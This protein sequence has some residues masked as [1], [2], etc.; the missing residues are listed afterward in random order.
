MGPSAGENAHETDQESRYCSLIDFDADDPDLPLNWSFSRKIWVTSMVAILN[1]IGTIASSIFGTGI[2]EFMQE[3]NVSNEI[4]VQGTTLFLAGYIFGFLIFGPLSERFGRKWPML[5]G[6]TASSLFDL[7]PALGTNVATVLIGRFFGGLFGVAPVAI[8]G[9]V[10]GDCWPLAQRGIAM[11]LAVS[12]V[13]SGPTWGPSFVYGVM[14]LFYQMYPVAFGDDRNWTTSLK[15]LPLLAIITGTFVGALGIVLH[16]QLY[17]RHHCH[18][19]DGTYIPESRLPPMIVGCVMV[20]AGMFW[21]A[22]TASPDNVSWASPIC[23]SFMT[24]CGMYL[25][26]IQG[27]NYIIDCY[28]SMANSAMGING[29]MRS[30][31]GAVFPL[32]ANQM[33]GALGVA[34][35][36]T[37]LAA[38]SVMLVP[39]PVCF[40]Y[41][42]SR[43]RAWSSAEV[44][45]S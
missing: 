33:V 35:T 13:F 20:P 9:G 32:F 28:T 43:I 40:W 29:S 2:K 7:M 11:A 39:V 34:K 14:F 37:V 30:V 12:L 5:I 41:W 42:G 26:F 3:F 10:L 25:L 15:Y 44:I 38:V 24:G 21:F 1:L 6:I 18:N 36:T 8:F 45:G 27:W 4:A 22:W 17:F 16:N 31:F 23:A 19:P